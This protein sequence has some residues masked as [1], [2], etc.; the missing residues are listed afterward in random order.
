VTERCQLTGRWKLGR[1]DRLA[2]L[3]AK[4]DELTRLVTGLDNRLYG[5]ARF[6][7]PFYYLGGNRGLT[8]LE[9]GQPFIVDTSDSG[10]TPWLIMGGH[11]ETWADRVVSSYV[12]PGM[13]IVDVGANVGYYATKWGAMIGGT[14]ELHAF[15]PNPKLAPFIH[16]NFTLSGLHH[17]CRYYTHAV[18]AA[19]GEATLTLME[20]S[21]GL[22]TLR[23]AEMPPGVVTTHKV[24]VAPLDGVLG[25]MSHVDLMKIDVEGYE[26]SVIDGAKQLI[27]RSPDC[28]FHLEVQTGWEVDGRSIRETLRPLTDGRRAFVIGRDS[29]LTSIQP[30]EIRDFVFGLESGL[31][32]FFVCPEQHLPRVAAFLPE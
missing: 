23:G 28:A 19:Y 7:A 30:D 32:D 10:L 24:V 26:P 16:E 18:G 31:A 3:E 6:R 17:H 27:A 14:G 15:E 1:V 25:N 22:A 13:K 12:R 21:T 9:T 20:N 11:W 2:A 4:V 5:A 8:Y 29:R